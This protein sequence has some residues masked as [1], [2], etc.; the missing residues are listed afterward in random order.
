MPYMTE[1]TGVKW[2]HENYRPTGDPGCFP[3]D[4][5]RILRVREHEEEKSSRERSVV[6]WQRAVANQ[7]GRASDHMNVRDIGGNHLES[8]FTLQMRCEMSGARAEVQHGA[9]VRKPFAN[10]P[11][12]LMGAPFHDGIKRRLQH[13][14]PPSDPKRSSVC[15]R[16]R[17]AAP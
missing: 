12:Q 16:S 5:C 8:Q 10:L 13:H 4:R 6:E 3:Q 15:D 14:T 7:D 9:F 2:L 1:A 11:Q 17:E